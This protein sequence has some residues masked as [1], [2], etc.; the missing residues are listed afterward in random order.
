MSCD[1]CGAN[2]AKKRARIEGA[3]VT[4]C[5]RCVSL[6]EEIPT[7]A[8]HALAE[9]ILP[10]LSLPPELDMEMRPDAAEMVKNAREKQGL[11]Q[12]QL[13]AKVSEK[14]NIIRRVEEGW[15]PSLP[16]VRKLEKA[17]GIELLE[18]APTGNLKTKIQK[19]HLTLGDVA[20]VSG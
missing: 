20:E 13:A 16:V 11:T 4:V 8:I 3:V 17:L 7:Q 15:N 1:I 14:G 18:T 6:G 10:K 2:D 5:D 9:R 19:K 12:E